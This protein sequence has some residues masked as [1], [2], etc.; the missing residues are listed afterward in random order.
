MADIGFLSM[1][2]EISDDLASCFARLLTQAP[3][4]ELQ[5]AQQKGYVTYT[6][7]LQGPGPRT[8]TLLEARSI[9]GSSGDTGLRTWEAALRLGSFLCSDDGRQLID[10][11]NILELGAGSG[12]LSILCAK[13]LNARFVV[14]TDGSREVVNELQTNLDLNGLYEDRTVD[15]MILDWGHLLT[16]EVLYDKERPRTYELVLGSDIV[17]LVL[18]RLLKRTAYRT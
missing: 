10:G 18:V 9:L 15:A 13:L 2:Q 17:S 5:L 8:I 3:A 11:K 4:S 7:Q 12:F 6:A 16:E 1:V 14:A